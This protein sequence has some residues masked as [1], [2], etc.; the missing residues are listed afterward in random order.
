ML[1]I[2]ERGKIIYFMHGYN[3][4]MKIHHYFAYQFKD[5]IE[6]TKEMSDI[7]VEIYTRLGN[8]EYASEH[9]RLSSFNDVTIACQD[10]LTL[11][12]RIL[13]LKKAYDM[14]PKDGVVCIYTMHIK[15]HLYCD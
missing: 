7:L 13:F 2:K 1:A 12:Q 6:L 11:D 8:I 3:E 15:K 10:H 9:D 14:D 5:E 4:E